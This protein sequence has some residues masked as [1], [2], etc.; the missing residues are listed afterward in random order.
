[1]KLQSVLSGIRYR[2][3][4]VDLS[5]T[6]RQIRYDSRQV[7]PGDLFVAIRGF[8]TDGHQFIASAAER[9][10]AAIICEEKPALDIPYVLVD[11]C[12]QA[13]AA[14]SRNFYGDPAS[15]LTMIA[16]TGTNGKTTTA[17]LLKHMI[18]QISGETVGLIG[19]NHN[20]IGDKILPAELTTP[21]SLDLQKLLFYM[22]KAGCRYA[23]MEVSSHSLAL[24]RVDG[25]LFHTA[26]FT[27]LTHDHLDFHKTMCEYAHVKASL[28]RQCRHGVINLDDPWSKTIIEEATCSLLTYSTESEEA[29]F[30]AMLPHPFE[31]GQRF[32]VKYHNMIR[33]AVLKMPGRYNIYNA[34]AA[35]AAA[36]TLFS[37]FEWCCRVLQT[38]PGITGRME[39]IPVYGNYRMFIDFAHTPDALKQALQ[40]AKDM[41]WRQEGGRVVVVFGCGGD[42]DPSKRPEMG[43][44]AS[45]FADFC[46]ITS[47]NPRTEDPI[48]IIQDILFGMDDIPKRI[49][50]DRREAICWIMDHHNDHDIVVL[51]GKGHE[52]YQII[53]DKKL[54][55]DEHEIIRAHRRLN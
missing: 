18:E 11:N 24:H 3:L 12:R 44:I 19:T 48:K 38:A 41:S 7:K 49:I 26:V 4:S 14:M 17:H 23:V 21:E 29:D 52:N 32:C 40:C 15:K 54:P 33:T 25:I 8:H 20:M 2:D 35:I 5:L 27:N 10:A 9:G 45:K 53:G 43:E 34:L 46:I 42:R 1:M 16:V 47:D 22:V 31:D 30:M 6:V 36:F 50:P 39:E 51:C 37:G 13:L 28:F 55:F